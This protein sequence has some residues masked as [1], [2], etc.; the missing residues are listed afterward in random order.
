MGRDH[1]HVFDSHPR[2]DIDR[3][4]D[5][6]KIADPDVIGYMRFFPDGCVVAQGRIAADMDMIP[7]GGLPAD[8]YAFLDQSGRVNRGGLLNFG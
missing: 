4:I 8:P 5:F 3:G 2:A 7:D 1:A 6:D